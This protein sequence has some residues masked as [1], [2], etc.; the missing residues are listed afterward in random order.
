MARGRLKEKLRTVPQRKMIANLNILC[1]RHDAVFLKVGCKQTE[2][3][4]PDHYEAQIEFSRSSIQTQN[5]FWKQRS[6]FLKRLEKL[7]IRP[8]GCRGRRS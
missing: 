8:Y 4:H 5:R 3:D 6:M 1:S 2:E 7:Y